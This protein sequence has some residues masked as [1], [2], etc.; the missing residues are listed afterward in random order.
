[1]AHLTSGPLRALLP[2]LAALAAALGGCNTSGCL[3]NQ[4]SIPLAGLYDSATGSAVTVSGLEVGG[5]GAPADSLLSSGSAI[6]Q[7][8]LPLRSLYSS[9]AFYF[10]Y[11]A[12]E[13]DGGDAILPDTITIRYDSEPY[14]ASEECGAMYRYRITSLAHTTHAIDSV[15]IL[16]SLVTNVDIQRLHIYL[17]LSSSAL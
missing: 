2:L 3:D 17:R 11:P 8:Y 4:N 14:L 10:R 9:A 7:I 1:M 12:T 16:D 13:A 15:A 6:S 5:V